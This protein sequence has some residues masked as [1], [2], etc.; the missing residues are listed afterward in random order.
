LSEH[1][2]TGT[3]L[4]EQVAVE[5]GDTQGHL[6][7]DHEALTHLVRRLLEAEGVARALVSVVL[8]DN[9]TIRD[10]NRRH[11]GHDWPTDVIGFR[12]SEAREPTLT[13]ELVVSTEMAAETAREAGVD[14][15]AELALYVVHGLLHWCGYDD[16][17]AAGAAAMRRR[18]DEILAS[19]G[20]PNPFCQVGPA[21][22][23]GAGRERTRWPV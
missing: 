14:P 10:V 17:T 16:Q 3:E 12:L 9:A 19:E 4:R 7:V 13:G 5:V 2:G 21:G 8:V 20:L 6:K 11:L 18:E 23:G 1:S 22:A 15:W